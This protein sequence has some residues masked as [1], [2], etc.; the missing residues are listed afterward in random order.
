[1]ILH[2]DMVYDST[3]KSYLDVKKW[4]DLLNVRELLKKLIA[5]SYLLYTTRSD[6][7]SSKSQQNWPK[8]SQILLFEQP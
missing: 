6:G 7:K 1:M 8:S 4:Y 2:T 5:I 3:H